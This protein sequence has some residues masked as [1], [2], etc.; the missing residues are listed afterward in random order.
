M[1]TFQQAQNIT[2]TN[3][4]E[5]ITTT[6]TNTWDYMTTTLFNKLNDT[7]NLMFGINVTVTEINQTTHQILD[8]QENE[9]HINIIS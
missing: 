8:N 9:V 6:T 5:N 3:Y 2:F 4:F 7:Y 1:T